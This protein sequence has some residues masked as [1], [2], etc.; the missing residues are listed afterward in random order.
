M[1]L[2]DVQRAVATAL[3][4]G[5]LPEG[6]DHH[7]LRLASVLLVA[8]RRVES[9]AW[10][11]RTRA[12]LGPSWNPRFEQHAATYRPTGWNHPRDDALAFAT[13]VA[14]DPR[15]P[16][17]IRDTARFEHL[18]ARASLA[19]PFLA[20]FTVRADATSPLRALAGLHLWWRWGARG[21]LHH[22]HLR[23][24]GLWLRDTHTR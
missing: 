7:A 13:S 8:K 5:E 11:P 2:A 16:R 10:L 17:A 12:A 23:W 3:I 19:E 4:G 21:R 9:A 20:S 14:G 18:Q 24:P 15:L 6:Y 22:H 1:T